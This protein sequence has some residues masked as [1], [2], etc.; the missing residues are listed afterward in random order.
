MIAATLTIPDRRMLRQERSFSPRLPIDPIARTWILMV[1]FATMQ[2]IGVALMLLDELTL[3]LLL[4][5]SFVPPSRD[6]SN[7][8]RGRWQIVLRYR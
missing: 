5:H 2:M 1:A 8:S 6:D 4:P 7:E 3:L